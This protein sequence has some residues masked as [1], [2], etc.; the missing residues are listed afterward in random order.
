M[1]APAA[2]AQ[3]AT[4]GSGAYRNNILWFRWGASGANIAQTGATITN[5]T[6]V[7]DQ[8][9][10]MTCSLSNITGTG[11]S[12]AFS[13]YR[14]GS[15]SG[16][17]LD[18]L[19]NIAGTGTAN[20]L[21]V[22]LAT[23]VFGSTATARFSCSATFGPSNS[24][25]DPTFPI[26]GLVFA[27]A[28]Q[29]WT[30]QGEFVAATLNGAGTF[31]ILE[32]FRTSGCT[33]NGTV[34]V[35][36]STMTMNGS[37]PLCPSGPMAIGFLDGATSAD[38][39]LKGGGSSAIALG[40]MVFVADGGDAP[41]S[42]GDP[43]HLPDFRFTGGVPSGANWNY[44]TN[45]LA[46]LSPP[47]IRLGARVDTETVSLANANASGDD[48][49]GSDDEDAFASL[50]NLRLRAGGTHTLAVPCSGGAAATVYGYIDFNRDG[51]FLDPNERSAAAACA[52]TSANVTWTQ[53]A[54]SGLADGP[55]F[56]RLRIG[57]TASQLTSPFG[58]ASGGEV[59]D[60]PI[61][62]VGA[63]ISLQKALGATGRRNLNDQFVLS[64]AP[65]GGSATTRTTTGAGTA[66][67]SD[68]AV[69]DPATIGIAHTLSETAAVT[70]PATALGR[71]QSAYQCSN[72]L[73]GGQTPSGS[74]ASFAVTP[75]LDD[76]LTCTFTNTW[77]PTVDLAVA[78]TNAAAF[79]IR[80]PSD[81]ADDAVSVGATTYTLSVWNRGPDDVADAIVR[82]A[83]QAG[84]TCT[85][86]VSCTSVGDAACP[87]AA[88]VADLTG[89][90]LTIPRIAASA[91][92][93]PQNYLT[94]QVP[95]Q[96]Q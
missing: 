44:S 15:F 30:G 20:T 16:D 4:G 21:V 55:S 52:G 94:L 59:E 1:L 78:K 29:S 61:V 54:A 64:I 70:T 87:G 84:L 82:D 71:Y 66:I 75:V 31:R 19:Y 28:E 46:Q 53:P 68:A 62:L 83:P 25:A 93:P 43:H 81:A 90:G 37:N 40:V 76:E 96:V 17:G 63:T 18:D 6:R 49:N 50:P 33:T 74:G 8:F 7:D 27:D 13:A 69:L 56:L 35:A 92:T 32:T 80:T 77:A 85:G 36:G 2:Q 3:F 88:T 89:A 51:D 58:V 48:G 45:A 72:A 12:P 38:I 41:D 39:S 26:D 79:D 10:R 23:R 11:A 57:N 95:C 22:G 67:T 42:Y 9:L 14:P 86:A 91:A 5:S 73:P 34:T 60:H 24:S 65:A 47:L